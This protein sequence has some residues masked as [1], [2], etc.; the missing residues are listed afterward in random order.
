MVRILIFALVAACAGTQHVVVSFRV[1]RVTATKDGHDIDDASPDVVLA[2]KRVEL[3]TPQVTGDCQ[4]LERTTDAKIR[5]TCGELKPAG[6]IAA[7]GCG[8]DPHVDEFQCVYA[9]RAG[10]ALELWRADVAFENEDNEPLKL[11]PKPL[12]RVGSVAIGDANVTVAAVE[13]RQ[14]VR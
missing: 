10:G 12:V 11:H 9:V 4:E 13:H 1:E 7:L 14:T 8:G 5:K 3:R 6:T 2:T